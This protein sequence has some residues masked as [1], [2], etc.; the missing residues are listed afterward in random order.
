M[1][2][3]ASGLRSRPGNPENPL[4]FA[5]PST[6]LAGKADRG[7]SPGNRRARMTNKR[8]ALAL[9]DERYRARR[10]PREPEARLLSPGQPASASSVCVVVATAKARSR[11][12]S[13]PQHHACPLR[14]TYI[15]PIVHLPSG[16]F[17]AHFYSDYLVDCMVT[18][19]TYERRVSRCL[20]GESKYPGG[21][22]CT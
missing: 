12:E 14:A 18:C 5:I 17:K 20:P 11:S 9:G 15:M 21:S 10:Q 19:K 16:F 8:S 2:A 4:L 7:G 22:R 3:G 1:P 6:R 13:A